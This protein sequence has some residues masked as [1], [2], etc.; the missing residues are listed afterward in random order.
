MKR[1]F[2][3]VL[4][5]GSR[6]DLEGAV[7]IVRTLITLIRKLLALINELPYALKDCH[8]FNRVVM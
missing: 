3:E 4:I 5:A 2:E 7:V 6:I 8:G 1:I